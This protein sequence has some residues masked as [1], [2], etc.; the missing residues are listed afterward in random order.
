MDGI[1]TALLDLLNGLVPS[2]QQ[3]NFEGLNELLAYVLTVWLVYI[4]IF[5]PL[6]KIT[7]KVFKL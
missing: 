5:A 4:F 6:F 1:Y 3:A 2:A 7:K